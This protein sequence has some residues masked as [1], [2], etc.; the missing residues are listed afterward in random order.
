MLGKLHLQEAQE[1]GDQLLLGVQTC[2][3]ICQ[4]ALPATKAPAIAQ[5]TIRMIVMPNVYDDPAM[6]TKACNDRE[7]RY[8]PPLTED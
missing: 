3:V 4:R 7:E 1:A 2:I 8:A 6:A 5:P